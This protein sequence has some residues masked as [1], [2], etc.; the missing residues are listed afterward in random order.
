MS[1]YKIRT[2]ELDTIDMVDA[3]VSETLVA[4]L[5]ALIHGCK[6]GDKDDELLTLVLGLWRGRK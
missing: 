4:R 6:E 1:P 2:R 5:R 3:G